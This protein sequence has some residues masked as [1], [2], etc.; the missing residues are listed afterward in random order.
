MMAKSIN[1][2]NERQINLAILTRW[3]SWL[4]SNQDYFSVALAKHCHPRLEVV[5][6]D[7][8]SH[9]DWNTISA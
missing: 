3:R 9:Q 8:M 4:F 1:S 7:A 6:D 5:S 2:F